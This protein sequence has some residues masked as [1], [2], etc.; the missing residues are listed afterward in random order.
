MNTNESALVH[1]VTEVLLST[2]DSDVNAKALVIAAAGEVSSTGWKN[3]GLSA[4]VYVQPPPDGIWEFSFYAEPPVG[5]SRP[6]VTPIEA[7]YVMTKVP[8]GLRGVRVRAETNS[9]EARLI[10]A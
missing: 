1:S 3:P 5:T 6:V 4:P 9:V 7:T 10:S 8:A 2:C